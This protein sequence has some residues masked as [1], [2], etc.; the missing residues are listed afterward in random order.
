MGMPT[1][2]DKRAILSRGAGH[3]PR[4]GKGDS[5]TVTTHLPIERTTSLVIPAVHWVPSANPRTAVSRPCVPSPDLLN[6]VGYVG[7]SKA[8]VISFQRAV[9]LPWT[10]GLT[11]EEVT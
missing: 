3:F 5:I 6:L 4:T 9:F 2:W 11:L 10:I 1:E 8:G 7:L